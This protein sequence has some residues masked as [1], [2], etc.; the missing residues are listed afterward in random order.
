MKKVILSVCAVALVCCIGVTT[1]HAFCNAVCG[2]VESRVI[3]EGDWWVDLDGVKHIRNQVV[4]WIMCDGG[5]FGGTGYGVYN[6]D[7]NLGTGVGSIRG[8]QALDLCYQNELGSTPPCYGTFVGTVTGTYDNFFLSAQYEA[9]GRGGF[10]DALLSIGVR[11]HYELAELSFRGVYRSITD[12][13][14]AATEAETWSNVKAL[15]R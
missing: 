9:V 8:H 1:A 15:Y 13:E 4:Q 11:S 10:A 7:I 2:E 3:R 12:G 5:C 6:I 14:K